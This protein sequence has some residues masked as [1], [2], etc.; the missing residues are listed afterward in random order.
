M[1]LGIKVNADSEALD[2][3]TG[4]NPD[5][6]EV[7]FNVNDAGRY[8]DLFDEL[9]Q[10]K[11]DVGLHFWGTL[12]T[13]IA[14]NLAYPDETTI[15]ESLDLMRRTIDI[16]SERQFQYVNIH[17]GSAALLKVNYKDERYDMIKDPVD[18]DR[19]IDLFLENAQTLHVYA[20]KHNVVFTVETVPVRITDGWYK[21]ET[22]LRPKNV[23][24]LPVEAILRAARLGIPIAN[25]FCHTAANVIS[26]DPDVVWTFLHGTTKLLA[27]YTRLIHLG[28]VMPPFNGTDS[29]DQLDN[30]IFD[31][32][33]AVPNKKQMIDLLKNF[34][35]RDDVWILVEPSTDH[36]K[37]Y[38]L[39][40]NIIEQASII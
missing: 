18:T 6:V 37:N 29:H 20:K 12:N 11:C 15:S 10:R 32:D 23:F 4:S 38:F 21:A 19:A 35:N 9:K 8:S 30:P 28:F 34:R 24:E 14:P 31:T 13:D 17:P 1:K 7:W 2:R 5:L 3:L 36:V 27:P 22:R 25:D 40:K 16:A 33:K 39:A 26:D